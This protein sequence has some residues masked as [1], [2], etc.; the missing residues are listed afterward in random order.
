MLEAAGVQVTAQ[1]AVS[2][3]SVSSQSGDVQI[4]L[5]CAEQVQAMPIIR[6]A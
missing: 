5:A 6:L 3:F 2:S 1:R 4:S